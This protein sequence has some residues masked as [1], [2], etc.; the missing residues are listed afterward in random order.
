MLAYPVLLR[1]LPLYSPSQAPTTATP[2]PPAMS[3]GTIMQPGPLQPCQYSRFRDPRGTEAPIALF[4]P[5]G[6]SF[7]VCHLHQILA[8]SSEGCQLKLGDFV[9]RALMLTKARLA[10]WQAA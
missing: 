3:D 1:S 6:E 8:R 2:T 7:R 4:H 5:V 10:L 9:L